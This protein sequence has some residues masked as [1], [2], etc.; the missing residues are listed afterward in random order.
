MVKGKSMYNQ[1]TVEISEVEP[2]FGNGLSLKFF[3]V[4][5]K[6][7]V[8]FNIPAV[9]LNLKNL[10]DVY[11]LYGDVSRFFSVYGNITTFIFQFVS[12][13]FV[14]R[15]I[16]YSVKNQAQEFAFLY[17]W[18]APINVFGSILSLVLYISQYP[19]ATSSLLSES[20]IPIITSIIIYIPIFIYLKKRLIKKPKNS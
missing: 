4:L 1:D 8:F 2:I 14:I 19:Q 11:Q 5:F 10:F 3:D 9:L 16:M 7:L 20:V 13:F 18:V 15:L 6:V 12:V 17:L